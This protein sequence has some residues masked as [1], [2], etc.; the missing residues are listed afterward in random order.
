MKSKEDIVYFMPRI[1]QAGAFSLRIQ[2][3]IPGCALDDKSIGNST[4]SLRA[5]LA[6]RLRPSSAS[7]HVAEAAAGSP[8][9]RWGEW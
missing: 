3:V 9:F 6:G 4:G 8:Q 2:L 1:V 7:P 5:D